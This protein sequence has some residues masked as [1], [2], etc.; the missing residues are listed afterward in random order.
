MRFVVLTFVLYS[1]LFAYNFHFIK[2]ETNTSAP[3]L[4]VIGGIHGNEPGGYFAVDVLAQHYTITQGNLWMIPDLNRPSIIQNA[5]GIYGDMNRKFA[6]ISKKDHEF[7]TVSDVK[8]IITKKNVSLVI[9]LHD[10]HGF[11]RKEY[12]STIFN[13]NAWGQTCVIDQGNIESNNSFSDLSCIAEQVSKILNQDLIKEHHAFNVRNTKTKF[14]DEA[15]QHS[16]TYFAVTH[17]KPAFALETSKSLDSLSQKVYYQLKAIEAFMNIMK[18]EYKRDFELTQNSVTNII[19]NYGNIVINTNIALDLTNIKK[20]LSFI[21]LQS[22]HNGF[23]FSHLLGNM[24]RV[25]NYYNLYIGNKKITSL[26]AQYFKHRECVE[27]VA[28]EIDKNQKNVSFSTEISVDA[29]FKV[30]T[31][32]KL[33]VN[34]IGFTAKQRNESG[35]TIAYSDLNHNF[36]VDK[37]KKIYRVEFYQDDSFCG[38]VTVNFK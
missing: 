4:L 23:K 8:K 22:R 12:Q 9:N 5:R 36:S 13:P 33:R 24:Q 18:I 19:K 37:A 16:L 27:N 31:N 2:K 26:K 3:T 10:G 21:P 28:F 38:M 7:Q 25:N 14:D 32:E 30:I 35:I 6:S 15:M 1:T 34:I 29:D 17:H 11:Y 20:N